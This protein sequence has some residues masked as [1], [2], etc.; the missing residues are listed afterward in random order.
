MLQPRIDHT[1]VVGCLISISISEEQERGLW[2]GERGL[3]LKCS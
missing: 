1:N 3:G 2:F